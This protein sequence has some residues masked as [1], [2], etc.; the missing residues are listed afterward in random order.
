MRSADEFLKVPITTVVELTLVPC[1]TDQAN[2]QLILQLSQRNGLNLPP[3]P[4]PHPKRHHQ[5][6][7]SL[8]F[9]VIILT[10]VLLL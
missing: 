6:Q 7:V 9:S 2:F 1:C 8:L 10:E 5:A 4:H 3:T